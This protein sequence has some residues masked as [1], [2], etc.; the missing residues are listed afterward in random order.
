MWWEWL[1]VRNGN[2]EAVWSVYR[3]VVN[4]FPRK[5][6]N[7]IL[8]LTQQIGNS[9]KFISS[10]W[11]KTFHDYPYY[12]TLKL[13]TKNECVARWS[14]FNNSSISFINVVRTPNFLFQSNK[15]FGEDGTNSHAVP[16][17]SW[18]RMAMGVNVRDWG[19]GG[20]W[21]CLKCLCL[22]MRMMEIENVV[23]RY[24]L[25]KWST[26]CEM[27]WVFGIEIVKTS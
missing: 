10:H 3:K 16:K 22:T 8:H 13:H 25:D 12:G 9:Q 7:R 21:K 18:L 17:L 19:G 5:G 4:I 24:L 14:N 15:V 23:C 6:R 26:I 27:C 20:E 11:P 1:E 2:E